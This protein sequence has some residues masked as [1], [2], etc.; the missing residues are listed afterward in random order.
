MRFFSRTSSPIKR[1]CFSF[2]RLGFFFFAQKTS[3][4]RFNLKSSI[5]A[6][7]VQESVDSHQQYLFGSV[8]IFSNSS[9]DSITNTRGMHLSQKEQKNSIQSMENHSRFC[10][11]KD[12]QKRF[13][14]RDL[15]FREL[16]MILLVLRYK[17]HDHPSLNS[18]N[19]IKH[20][21][22]SHEQNI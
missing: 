3:F 7:Y 20:E 6:W 10:F 14:G 5:Q 1:I 13:C 9:S 2:L 18:S 15:E 22:S 21:K 12:I 19:K 11:Q 16:K 4:V 17:H 8:S